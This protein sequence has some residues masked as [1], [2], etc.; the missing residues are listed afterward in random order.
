VL[1]VPR[2][3]FLLTVAVAIVLFLIGLFVLF[4]VDMTVCDAAEHGAAKHCEPYH[5]LV[6]I[7]LKVGQI[8]AHAEV[9]TAL[10]TIAIACFTFFLKKS[11][12][13]LWS[14]TKSATEGTE[15]AVRT[16]ESAWIFAAPY[17]HKID[18][19]TDRK[20]RMY[21]SNH[22]KTPAL[23][24]QYHMEFSEGEPQGKVAFYKEKPVDKAPLVSGPRDVPWPLDHEF[25]WNGRDM[26]AYGF[27]DYL[28]AFGK[29]KVT[30]W[31]CLMQI[32]GPIRS[33]G[34]LAY[35]SFHPDEGV[36]A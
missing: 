10:G 9:W 23:I 17:L 5:I 33:A 12:D 30:R 3:S 20:L 28:D 16:V 14:A 22:G 18:L 6:A 8:L 1:T 25:T 13:N 15:K 27:V 7:P 29:P 11:T 24:T 32:D 31:C 21:V 2:W 4:P 35:N 36:E 26:F 19:R 34:S